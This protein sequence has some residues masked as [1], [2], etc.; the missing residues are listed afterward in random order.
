MMRLSVWKTTTVRVLAPV[1]ELKG[2]DMLPGFRPSVKD[3]F[4]RASEPA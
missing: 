4:N 3:L 1:D 2:S